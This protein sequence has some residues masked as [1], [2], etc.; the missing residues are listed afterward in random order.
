[1]DNF[2][3]YLN[4]KD[5]VDFSGE[6]NTSD[7]LVHFQTAYELDFGW[8]CALT[9][10]TISHNFL[11]RSK[12]LYFCCN[13]LGDTFVRNKHIPVIRNIEITTGLRQTEQH[14]TYSNLQYVPL[15]TYSFNSIHI[16]LRDEDLNPVT[17]A[18]D[19]DLHCVLHFKKSWA[20]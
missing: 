11:P 13:I 5:S 4:S 18:R 19:Q 14:I 3:L 9:D 12:R 7:F 15:T 16:F 1:M 8:S 20:H 2:Y 17:F 6:Q 10:L